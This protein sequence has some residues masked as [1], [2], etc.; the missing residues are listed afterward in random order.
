MPPRAATHKSLQRRLRRT[1]NYGQLRMDNLTMPLSEMVVDYFDRH[2]PFDYL[3]IGYA[4]K[5]ARDGC[6]DPTTL[7]IAMLY[8]DR[9]RRANPEYFVSTSPDDIYLSALVIA[10]K[11]LQDGGLDEFIWNDEWA[12]CSSK[13]VQRVNEL[14]LEILL[15]I[16]WNLH[17]S[18]KEFKDAIESAEQWI[19]LHSLKRHKF[20]TYNDIAVLS[21]KWDASWKQVKL[22]FTFTG[23]I[24]ATYLGTF[25]FALLCA[26]IYQSELS[27]D[28]LQTTP[29][30][31]NETMPST[32]AASTPSFNATFV[33][34]MNEKLMNLKS[35]INDSCSN[36]SIIQKPIIPNFQQLFQRRQPV[37]VYNNN[38]NDENNRWRE[39]ECY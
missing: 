35:I 10:G 30:L 33:Y 12:Q 15:K 38:F 9:L 4:S 31:T 2:N 32:S 36:D 27:I 34:R 21:K 5:L 17:V 23:A 16:D 24:S 7:I 6:V 11:F 20:L 19:A 39:I 13:T 8:V 29:T 22:L 18:E 37:V 28:V 3:D 14:E 1:M 25:Y 26:S